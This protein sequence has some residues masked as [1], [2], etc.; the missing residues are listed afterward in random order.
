MCPAVHI[1]RSVHIWA[2]KYVFELD[3]SLFLFQDV[4]FVVDM[5]MLSSY[6]TLETTLW[7]LK[8][9]KEKVYVGNVVI[10]FKI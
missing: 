8:R 10:H 6:P 2:E 5:A 9:A 3:L 7:M 1:E 4:Q